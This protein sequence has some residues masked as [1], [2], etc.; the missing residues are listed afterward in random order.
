M[1]TQIFITKINHQNAVM[2]EI[3]SIHRDMWFAILS[4]HFCFFVYF[5]KHSLPMRFRLSSDSQSSYFSFLNQLFSLKYTLSKYLGTDRNKKKS[6]QVSLTLE[7]IHKEVDPGT[8]NWKTQN[9]NVQLHTMLAWQSFNETKA[10]IERWALSS[11]GVLEMD[12]FSILKKKSWCLRQT[13]LR[14]SIWWAVAGLHCVAVGCGL[15]QWLPSICSLCLAAEL[16]IN[17]HPL[18][19]L[20]SVFL[21]PSRLHVSLEENI[22]PA[23]S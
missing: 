23:F 22:M 8:G 5:V 2:W 7:F 4:F 6:H 18:L 21:R 17:W 19:H 11:S 10:I 14:L 13:A 20:Q 12:P 3:I 16:H 15:A 1:E 9:L